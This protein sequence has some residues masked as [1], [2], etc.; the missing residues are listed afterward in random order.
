[1]KSLWNLEHHLKIMLKYFHNILSHF[2]NVILSSVITLTKI[3]I[4]SERW[5]YYCIESSCGKVGVQSDPALDN[6]WNHWVV[7]IGISLL[8]VFLLI[9]SKVI[10]RAFQIWWDHSRNFHAYHRYGQICDLV[11][12]DNV[13]IKTLLINLIKGNHWCVENRIAFFLEFQGT[14]GVLYC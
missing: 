13:I 10:L 2:A 7:H 6:K 3:T 9:L 11:L 5:Y 12:I 1:M 14:N 8:F 4:I